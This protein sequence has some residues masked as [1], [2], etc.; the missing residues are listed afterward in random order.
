MCNICTDEAWYTTKQLTIALLQ[1]HSILSSSSSASS[2]S[3]S[4]VS[5]MQAKYNIKMKI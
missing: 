2:S 4:N 5:Y 3:S 1:K